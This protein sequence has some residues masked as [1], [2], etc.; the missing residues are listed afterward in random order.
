MSLTAPHPHHRRW[1]WSAL[2]CALAA[3]TL[4]AGANPTCFPLT[5]PA[6]APIEEVEIRVTGEGATGSPGGSLI[7][8]LGFGA[9]FSTVSSENGFGGAHSECHLYFDPN[10][11]NIA[12]CYDGGLYTLP[13]FTG[14]GAQNLFRLDLGPSS[15]VSSGA[16]VPVL[17]DV[18]F[19]V[20]RRAVT[21]RATRL[22]YGPTGEVAPYVVESTFPVRNLPPSYFPGLTTPAIS[23]GFWD[24]NNQLCLE[25]DGSFVPGPP[26]S[27]VLMSGNVLVGGTLGAAPVMPVYRSNGIFSNN[28]SPCTT[29]SASNRCGTNFVVNVVYRTR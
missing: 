6:G 7:N 23:S 3:S 19:V 15:Q 2:A 5:S 20:T 18:T 17:R 22:S 27:D 8:A 13:G 10:G 29:P 12:Y 16:V 1:A 24:P 26:I 25:L 21:V 28:T 14:I 11:T 4:P 9:H